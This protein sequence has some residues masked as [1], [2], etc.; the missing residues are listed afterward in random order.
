MDT[1]TRREW[2]VMQLVKLGLRNQQ[3]ADHLFISERTVKSHKYNVYCKLGV[4]NRVA[5]LVV[6]GLVSLPPTPAKVKRKSRSR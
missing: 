4:N 6:L 3:I 5:A 1:L 2:E